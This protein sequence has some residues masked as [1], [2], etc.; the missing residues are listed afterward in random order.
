MLM[1]FGWTIL[2]LFSDRKVSEI[3]KCYKSSPNR[4]PG[5]KFHVK[6]ILFCSKNPNKEN[7]HVCPVIKDGY[8]P[9]SNNRKMR[10]ILYQWNR[11]LRR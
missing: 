11:Y 10:K 4:F 7:I 5:P 6:R 2:K 8:A 9:T 3:G 1:K